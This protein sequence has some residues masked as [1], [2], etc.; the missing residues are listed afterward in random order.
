MPLVFKHDFGH[1]G[2]AT[3]PNVAYTGSPIFDLYIE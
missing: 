3:G 2:T 1:I